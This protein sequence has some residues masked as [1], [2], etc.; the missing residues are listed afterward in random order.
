MN[1]KFSGTV[2]LNVVIES[3]HKDAFKDPALLHKIDALQEFVKDI[4]YVGDSLSV[5]DYLK[6]MNMSLHEMDPAYN[7]LPET[8]EL[9]AEDLFLFSVSGR[10]EQLD[11]VVDFDYRQGLVTISIQTDFTQPLKHIRD[12]VAG[13]VD[14]EFKDLNVDVNY[15]GSA[16]NSYIWADLLIG[17]QTS[18]I[19]FSK[20]AILI[21]AALVFLS[22]AAGIY[23][24]VPV[25]LSTLIVAGCAGWLGIPLD[26]STALA[27]GIAIGVGV[28]Y[29]VHYVYR[30]I[31]ER[32]SGLSHEE[33]TSA[34][35]RTTG[36]TIVLNAIVVSAGFAVLFLSQFPPHVK[37]GYF[38]TAY[39]VVSC[40]VAL[41]VL[42]A[43]FSMYQPKH[44][45]DKNGA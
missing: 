20:I 29:A 6:N 11:Q 2:F 23:V 4:P 32:K 8:R 7:T 3:E 18:A 42:P 17:S 37:L 40:L 25:T 9:I 26:V 41:V 38:V 13:F 33:A 35:L 5:V 45:V 19:V 12:E 31:A 24:V 39:M 36:R 43:M 30:Y 28:D 1:K 21:V 34:T 10:P 22:F 27:A 16:N 14:R 15:A 44:S